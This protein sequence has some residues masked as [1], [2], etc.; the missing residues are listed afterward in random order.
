MTFHN[1]FKQ[2]CF[3]Q[4]R[5]TSNWSNIFLM[6]NGQYYEVKLVIQTLKKKLFL[7]INK[8]P[9]FYNASK[10]TK[11]SVNHESSSMICNKKL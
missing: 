6:S 4:K 3:S 8:T 9:Y 5:K 7:N 10:K 1:K 2:E 11:F